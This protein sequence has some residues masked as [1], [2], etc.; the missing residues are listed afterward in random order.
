MEQTIRDA[1]TLDA[2]TQSLGGELPEDMFRDLDAIEVTV[3][4]EEESSRVRY[5]EM[6]MSAVMQTLM[7]RAMEKLVSN[8]GAGGME[9]SVTVE[10]TRIRV[11]MS[12]FDE[13]VSIQIPEGAKAG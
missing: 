7:E 12:H 1:G 2:L 13:L 5:Y 11:E 4:I 10:Q 9:V 3:G 6:D 8:M